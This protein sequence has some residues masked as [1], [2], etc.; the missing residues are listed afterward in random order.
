MRLKAVSKKRILMIFWLFGL[1]ALLTWGLFILTFALERKTY[2]LEYPIE[3]EKYSAKY[4]VDKYLVA[5]IIHC[6]SGNDSQA[7]SQKG[8]L[9]LMQIMP[10]T[11]EWAAEKLEIENYDMQMLKKPDINIEIGCWYLSFLNERF[12]SELPNMIAAYN[13]GHGRV[14]Q[15]LADPNISIDSELVNIPYHETEEYLK[16]VQRAYE[17]YKTLYKNEWI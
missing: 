3:I 11:G 10:D 9:G 6:E 1:V 8:A 17:K 2:K 7:Q 16:K 12:N 4:N 13:A 14:A 5:A 15:W